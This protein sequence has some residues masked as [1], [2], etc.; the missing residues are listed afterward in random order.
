MLN[1]SALTKEVQKLWS[2]V[3][4]IR[5][6]MPTRSIAAVDSNRRLLTIREATSLYSI[7]RRRLMGLIEKGKLP[8]IQQPTTTGY[9]CRWRWRREDCDALLDRA[10]LVK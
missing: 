2:A 5:A 8:A 4:A 6:E 1:K 9:L 7:G 10:E 3:E